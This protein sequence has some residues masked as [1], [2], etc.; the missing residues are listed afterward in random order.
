MNEVIPTGVVKTMR[1]EYFK[2]ENLP[3]ETDA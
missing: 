2:E 1:T 3:Y